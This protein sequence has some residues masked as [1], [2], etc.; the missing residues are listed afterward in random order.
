L[1]ELPDTSGTGTDLQPDA[2]ATAAANAARAGLSD[3]TRFLRADWCDGITGPFDIVVS[4]PPYI[5][6]RDIAGLAPEV[7]DHDPRAALD[8]GPDGLAPYRIILPALPSLLA[9]GGVAV[10]ECGIGQAADVRTIGEA[11]GLVHRE[12]R[13]DLGGVPRAVAFGLPPAR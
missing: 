13:A 9:E 4:N 5:P 10:M 11:A 2:L 3:R 7:R 6:S 12:T 8:G 1:S